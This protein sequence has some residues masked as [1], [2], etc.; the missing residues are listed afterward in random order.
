MTGG[1]GF[2]GSHL[3]D[4]LVECGADVSVIDDLSN[5]RRENLGSA[6][7]R[8]LF[9]EGSILDE[10]KLLEAARGRSG[11]VEIVFHQAALASVP[12]SVAEPG[13]FNE[14][15]VAGT[16]A[17]LEAARAAGVKRFIYAAS[18]SAY[19]E[20][21]TLP[22]VE[23]MLPA[24]RSPYA[25]TKLIGEHL[26][27]TWWRCYGLDGVSLRYFNIFGPRQRADSPYAAV[28]PRFA[29]ALRAGRKPVVYGDGAQTRDFTYVANAVHANLLAAV[30]EGPLQ[31]E[32][33]NIACGERFSLLHLLEAIAKEVGVEPACEFQP[34]RPGDV[35]HSLA[36]IDKA[37][38]LIGYEPQV[39]F[40]EG[41]RRTLRER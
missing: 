17:V 30:C 31:G 21:P 36:R 7:N 6:L 9:V 27:Q 18:S 16:V 39:S 25:A 11:G 8:V 20:S 34:A 14:V 24:P 3:V 12:R 19:G 23:S 35:R 1:A 29:E 32:T 28:I 41:L 10:A 37:R 26:V 15:N 13:H 40:E 2:I 5:G 4:A 33:V 22:K 38:E